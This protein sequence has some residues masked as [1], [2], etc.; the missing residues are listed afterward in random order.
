MAEIVC[1]YCLSRV[2]AFNLKFVCSDCGEEVK[3]STF[4]RMRGA[5][6]KCKNNKCRK[7]HPIDRLCPTCGAK[8]PAAI[9]D[10]QDY[11]RF[12]IIGISGAGKSNFLTT[13]LHE[14]KTSGLPWVFTPMDND[15]KISFR[16]YEEAVYYNGEPVPATPPGTPPLPMQ[17]SVQDK[18]KMTNKKIPSYSMTIFDGAGED[19]EHIDPTIS[20]YISGSE[21]LAILIDPLAL[22]GVR[23]LVEK[24][25][26][27]WSSPRNHQAEASADLVAGLADYIRMSR[28]VKMGNLLNVDVAIVFTKLDAVMRSF[29][30]AVVTQP[31]PHPARKAFVKADSDAVDMEIRDWLMRQ[32]E[33]SFIDAVDVNF[34]KNRVK[35]FGV[36][37]FGQ[38]PRGQNQLGKVIPHRVLDPLMWMLAKEKIVPTV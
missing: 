37:S 3:Q 38:P 31:S 10:Y 14:A 26:L 15:T 4:E 13:M 20:R 35:Y 16:D 9:L 7:L 11:L 36:S 17:W 2:N 5:A 23:S 27:D 33:N 1:P 32:G 34:A 19:H 12:S 22:P 21:S 30:S 28:G 24:N 29:G 6:P 18:T 8:L 25:V